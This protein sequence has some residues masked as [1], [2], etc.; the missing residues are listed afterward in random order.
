[1]HHC[2]QHAVLAT[3]ARAL[4]DVPRQPREQGRAAARHVGREA[5]VGQVR[6]LSVCVA[7][8]GWAGGLRGWGWVGSSYGGARPRGGCLVRAASS[9]PIHTCTCARAP[10]QVGLGRAARRHCGAR[11]AQLA[12][13]RAHAHRL[14]EPDPGQQ[15]VLRAVHVQHLRAAREWLARRVRSWRSGVWRLLAPFLRHASH[16]VHNVW[17]TCTNYAMLFKRCRCCRASSPWST[18]TCCTTSTAWACGTRASRTSWCVRGRARVLVVCVYK[19]TH[20]HWMYACVSIAPP[21]PLRAPQPPTSLP[22]PHPRARRWR[23]TAAC[24]TWTSPSA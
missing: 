2:C 10:A 21:N 1:M 15:R 13:A 16:W 24:R 18:S 14:D 11:R 20:L 7:A 5:H 6:K 9:P 12:A 4:R 17:W 8:C 3:G 19:R 23:P 22:S